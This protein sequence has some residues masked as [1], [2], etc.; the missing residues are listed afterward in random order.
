MMQEYITTT[1]LDKLLREIYQIDPSFTIVYD[2]N[3]GK[4]RGICQYNAVFEADSLSHL[5]VIVWLYY[6]REKI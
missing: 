2:K 6:F 3:S 4:T 5:I 1:P